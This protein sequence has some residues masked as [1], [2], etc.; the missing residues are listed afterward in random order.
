MFDGFERVILVCICILSRNVAHGL[1]GKVGLLFK[2]QQVLSSL[3]LS[4]E[5]LCA[6]S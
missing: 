6:K 1:L 4:A 2:H 3:L 5:K